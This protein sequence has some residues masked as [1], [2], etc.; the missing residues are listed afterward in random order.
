MK[1]QMTRVHLIALT[2]L[3]A[4]FLTLMPLPVGIMWMRP[5]WIFAVLL[6]WVIAIPSQ[7]SVGTAWIIGLLADLVMGTPLGEHALIFVVLIY[8][9]SKLQNGIVHFPPVQQACAIGVFAELNVT[10]HAFLLHT[11]GHDTHFILDS[12]SAVTTAI[13]WPWLYAVLDPL[14]PPREFVY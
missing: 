14:R 8:F 5:Q 13:I 12:L 10:L 2:F 6:F 11:T 3:I 9:I 4:I 1:T 7:Y